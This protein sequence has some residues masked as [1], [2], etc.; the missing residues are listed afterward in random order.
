MQVLQEAYLDGGFEK[1]VTKSL[2][3]SEPFFFVCQMYS[4]HFAPV[5]FQDLAPLQG[6]L[7]VASSKLGQKAPRDLLS[8][9][10]IA[11]VALSLQ[12]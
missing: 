10:S 1:H 6:C 11:Y 7:F 2:P 3:L 9:T 12:P 4:L 8:L 5:E